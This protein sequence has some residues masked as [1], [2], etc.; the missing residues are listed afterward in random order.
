MS[1]NLS[2]HLRLPQ[3]RSLTHTHINDQTMKRGEKQWEKK[4]NV[5]D[6]TVELVISH[7][8]I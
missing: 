7:A 3:S 8:N 2:R 4:L 5:F 1:D 6:R